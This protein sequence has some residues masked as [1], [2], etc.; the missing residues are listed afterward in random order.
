LLRKSSH[1]RITSR[2]GG[3]ATVNWM[4]LT[5]PLS[6]V[7]MINFMLHV[8]FLNLRE[9]HPTNRYLRDDGSAGIVKWD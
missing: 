8:K 6:V 1:I 3:R 7:K 4:L 2:D 5:G 9:N